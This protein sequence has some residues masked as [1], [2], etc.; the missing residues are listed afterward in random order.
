[1]DRSNEVPDSLPIVS[2]I[3]MM[4]LC[5]GFN[6]IMFQN[7]QFRPRSHR[8]SFRIAIISAVCLAALLFVPL[9]NPILMEQQI[10]GGLRVGHALLLFTMIV[11]EQDRFS[12][13]GMCVEFTGI[14]CMCVILAKFAIW[15]KNAPFYAVPSIVV[16]ISLAE[17]L[18]TTGVLFPKLAPDTRHQ[19][20]EYVDRVCL[21]YGILH[22]FVEPGP[23]RD[24]SGLLTEHQDMTP[25]SIIEHT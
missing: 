5:Y 20:C 21:D 11:T 13:F 17:A 8:R 24:F 2:A 6:K 16:A 3:A 18:W 22:H 1:M 9:V 19:I 25:E 15:T 12:C 7:P 4:I 23:I 14:A 10:F